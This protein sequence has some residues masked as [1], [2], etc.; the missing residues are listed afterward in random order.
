M[1]DLITSAEMFDEN[2][3]TAKTDEDT[4]EMVKTL[5]NINLVA[6]EAAKTDYDKNEA[7]VG[8]MSSYQLVTDS[9]EHAYEENRKLRDICAR[10]AQLF[11]ERISD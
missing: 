3:K 8:M 7:V 11:E 9:L 6:Y 4:I 2:E 10:F 5:G 1:E